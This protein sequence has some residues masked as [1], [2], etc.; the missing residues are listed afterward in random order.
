MKNLHKETGDKEPET[1]STE[2]LI[3]PGSGFAC[4]D[5]TI[6]TRTV[7]RQIGVPSC[8]VAQQSGHPRNSRRWFCI[9]SDHK[10]LFSIASF[11]LFIAESS[12]CSLR[13]TF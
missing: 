1:G 12:C 7:H 8:N 10:D 2:M 13:E 3:C 9:V 11:E 6:M 5:T 4:M